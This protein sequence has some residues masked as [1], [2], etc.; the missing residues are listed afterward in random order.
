[1]FAGVEEAGGGGRRQEIQEEETRQE[2]GTRWWQEKKWN[3]LW[4]KIVDSLRFAELEDGDRICE[5]W[6]K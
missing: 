6:T 1:M 4:Q 3:I 5:S 2:D